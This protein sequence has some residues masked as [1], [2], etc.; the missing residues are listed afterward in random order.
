MTLTNCDWI[1]ALIECAD[2]FE[3]F[4]TLG[5]SFHKGEN[6]VVEFHDGEWCAAQYASGLAQ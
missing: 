6:I 4:K 1:M 2:G 3:F 5:M